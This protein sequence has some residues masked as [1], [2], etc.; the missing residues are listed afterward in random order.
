[1]HGAFNSNQFSSFLTKS[2][3]VHESPELKNRTTN[4]TLLYGNW[5][6]GFRT[7]DVCVFITIKDISGELMLIKIIN[8]KNP[9][10]LHI[11]IETQSQI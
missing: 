7:S 4:T 8:N 6:V 2:S 10:Y 9:V 5:Q 11:K 1:M 3:C